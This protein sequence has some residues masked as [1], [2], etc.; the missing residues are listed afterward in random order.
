MQQ[1]MPRVRP[2]WVHQVLVVDG[3]ST[4]GTIE[5]AQQSGYDVL[6]QQERGLR[7]GYKEALRH[8]KGDVVITLS[9]DG[10]CVPEIIPQLIA[11]M[12]EGY[13]MVIASRYLGGLKSEDD[14]LVTRF[15]N[16]F[17]T[18]LINTLHGAQYTDALGIYR[19]WRKELFYALD[20]HVEQSYTPERLMHTVLSI[21]PLLSVRAAKRKLRC[22]EI[23]GPEP[24]R[25]SGE[26]KLQVVRWGS[27][28]LMQILRE[29]FYWN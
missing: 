23:Q 20:L 19:A 3:C 24:P 12:A 27:A 10:N 28:Y 16:W 6:V 1:I 17:F 11:K 2:E 4:D 9:P 18:F 5:Y 14:D 25:I 22:G 29:K 7:H 21:E 15:G 13:D 8:I 26:R